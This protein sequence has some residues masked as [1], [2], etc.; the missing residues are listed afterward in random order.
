ME[1]D[2]KQCP[3]CHQIIKAQAIKCRFCGNW[4]SDLNKTENNSSNLSAIGCKIVLESVPEECK[5]RVLKTIREITGAGLVEGKNIIDFTPTT[6]CESVSYDEAVLIKEKLE[7][8]GAVITFIDIANS[9][10]INSDTTSTEDIGDN[11]SIKDTKT[12]PFCGEEVKAIAKKC[13]HCGE[14][15]DKSKENKKNEFKIGPCQSAVCGIGCLILGFAFIDN[16]FGDFFWDNF[17]I[18]CIITGVV[19]SIAYGIDQAN[20]KN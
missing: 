14:F 8:A 20:M 15:F 17:V 6:V 16:G 11:N 4:L 7:K 1:R 9:A 5:I 12:C 13:M 10:V 2:E 19:S 18:I 3:S